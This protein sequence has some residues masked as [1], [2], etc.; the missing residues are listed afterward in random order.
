MIEPVDGWLSVTMHEGEGVAVTNPYVE[1]VWLPVIGP[2]AFLSYRR[3]WFW[4]S[5][6]PAGHVGVDLAAFSRM[7][8]VAYAGG[9]HSPL[10]RALNRLVR[11]GFAAA[12]CFGQFSI[13]STAPLLR[14]PAPRL[15][16]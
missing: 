11:F 3:L 6:E 7:L 2:T 15:R 16:P 12:P 14:E 5:A 4:V 8:G 9:R 1:T 10:P 13:R